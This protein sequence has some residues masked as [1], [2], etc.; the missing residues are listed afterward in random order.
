MALSL[1]IASISW[2]SLR[3]GLAGRRHQVA[4][5]SVAKRIFDGFAHL[6]HGA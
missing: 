4:I 2:S 1:T 3:I 6:Q 5:A